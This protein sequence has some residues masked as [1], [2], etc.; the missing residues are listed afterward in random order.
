MTAL[1]VL[2]DAKME[3]SKLSSLKEQFKETR[4]HFDYLYSTQQKVLD[5]MKEKQWVS[6]LAVQKLTSEMHKRDEALM[7]VPPNVSESLNS[8]L[9][10]IKSNSDKLDSL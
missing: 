2:V 8:L 10:K 9:T 7:K 1:K 6:L 3:E 4:E 5:T